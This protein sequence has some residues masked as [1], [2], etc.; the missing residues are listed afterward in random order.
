MMQRQLKDVIV[1]HFIALFPFEEV[2]IEEYSTSNQQRLFG[3]TGRFRKSQVE[4]IGISC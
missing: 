2:G 3:S 1:Q 4:C